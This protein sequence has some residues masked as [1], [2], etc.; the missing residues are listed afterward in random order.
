MKL[1]LKKKEVTVDSILSTFTTAINQLN[2][3]ASSLRND[4]EKKRLDAL[5]LVESAQ[6]DDHEY[7][8]AVAAVA[9]LER[10]FV[11]PVPV[12]TDQISA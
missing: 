3:L 7:E 10:L 11:T 8:R 4:S 6:K 1:S 12:E 5:A 2:G 9:N